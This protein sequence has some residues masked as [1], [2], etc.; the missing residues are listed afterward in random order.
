MSLYVRLIHKENWLNTESKTELNGEAITIDWKCK[1]NEWS[2]FKCEDSV[3]DLEKTDLLNKI[4]L[5]MVA[6]NPDSLS[7]GANLLVLDNRFIQAIGSDI[8]DDP[9]KLGC[10]HCNFKDINYGK[11]DKAVEYTLQ[12]KLTNLI[13]YSPK[14]IRGLLLAL[15]P[16]N[17]KDFIDYAKCKSGNDRLKRIGKYFLQ[18]EKN[19]F[20]I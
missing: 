2:V 15:S 20:S 14:E 10:Q 7:S 6:D 18:K 12:N 11:I 1:D 3:A 9:E 13:S 5:R 8:V 4:V 19:F 16:D 17:K